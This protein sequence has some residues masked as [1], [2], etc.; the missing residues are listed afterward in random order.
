VV[1]TVVLVVRDGEQELAREVVGAGPVIVV[2]GADRQESELA[3][4]RALAPAVLAGEI[5]TVL[6]HDGARPLVEAALIREVL[7]VAR[8]DGGAVPGLPRPGLAV[9][10]P[11]DTLAA[12]AEGLVAVQTPQ[13]FRARPLLEAYTAAAADGFSGTD[14]AACVARYAPQIRVRWVLGS[15]RNIKVPYAHDLTVA[16]RLLD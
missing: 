10:G 6:I 13:G 3:A 1:G 11:G 16:E 14:T 15:A 2:G 12:P 5:D 9:A 8:A 4:L 7:R